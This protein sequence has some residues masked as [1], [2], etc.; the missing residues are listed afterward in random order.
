MKKVLVSLFI[1]LTLFTAAPVAE[2]CRRHGHEVFITR[3]SGFARF[4]LEVFTRV[5]VFV[6]PRQ[7]RIDTPCVS[8]HAGGRLTGFARRRYPLVQLTLRDWFL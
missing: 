1:L 2:A 7:E 8:I 4:T 3:C 6:K 5:L